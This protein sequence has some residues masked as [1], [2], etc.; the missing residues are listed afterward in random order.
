MN[1]AIIGCPFRTSYGAYIESLKTSLERSTGSTVQWVASN[2]GCGDPIERSRDFQRRDCKYFEMPQLGE[3]PSPV[4][5]KRELRFGLRYATYYL[6]AV[7]YEALSRGTQVRHLHQILNAYGSD[8]AFHWLRRPSDA[9]RVV[10]VHE[11]DL[12]QLAYRDRNRIYNRADAIIVHDNALKRELSGLHVSP[13]LIHVVRHGTQI[14]PADATGQREGLVFY[15][16]H[17]LM[18]GKGIGNVLDALAIVTSRLG[19]KTPRLRI[20][21]HY[22]TETPPEALALARRSGVEERVDWLNQISMEDM[23]QLYR[24]SLL[25]LLPFTGSFAGLPA[26]VAAANQ[27]PVIC[28]R[29]AG[30]PGHIGDCGVWIDEENP[31]QLAARII[32]LLE[33][34]TLRRDYGGRLRRHAEQFLAWDVIARETFEIYRSA[35]QRSARM[36]A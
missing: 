1:I 15:G 4:P 30:L 5:W 33:D 31:V 26:G 29:K 6:R 8:V 19:D 17:K 12:E 3:M 24:S 21:G 9:T 14:G 36:R 20:H 16:G 10:T 2:C 18:S 25:C 7:R 32:D 22:G 23:M 27:L 34:E 11:L 28:T 35:Q 13:E